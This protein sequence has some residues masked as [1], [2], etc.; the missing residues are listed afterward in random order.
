MLIAFVGL[1]LLMVVKLGI[2][3]WAN[4]GQACEEGNLRKRV[5]RIDTEGRRSFRPLCGVGK[6]YSSPR[7][8][9]WRLH[10][11]GVLSARSD[12]PASRTRRSSKRHQDPI[13]SF[14]GFTRAFFPAS[15]D[16]DASLL[17]G[18]VIVIGALLLLPFLSGEGEKSWRR[19]PIA[20]LTILLV[21]V[22]L[23]TFT[24]LA[25]YT[26]GART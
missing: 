10:V 5:S 20:V 1:H 17:I 6:I 25:G 18:P 16:G 24:H 2:N 22:T 12:Q 21:A 23:A 13:T 14:C 3:E 26:H 4:A 8:S 19:R 7:L 15:V 11:R 9:C